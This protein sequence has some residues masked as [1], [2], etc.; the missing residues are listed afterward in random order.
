[1]TL[2]E[3]EK[4]RSFVNLTSMKT[5]ERGKE[6]AGRQRLKVGWRSED[7]EKPEV[8]RRL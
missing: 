7:T 1:M 5:D 8:E 4:P 3:I 2:P 6:V